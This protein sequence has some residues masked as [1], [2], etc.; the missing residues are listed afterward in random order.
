M[1]RYSPGLCQ[2]P[3]GKARQVTT[4]TVCKALLKRLSCPKIVGAGWL[5]VH[6]WDPKSPLYNV[7][8]PKH[9]HL[10]HSPFSEYKAA[11]W[12]KSGLRE[13]LVGPCTVWSVGAHQGQEASSPSSHC[14]VWTWP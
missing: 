13:E 3:E 6:P 4:R 2:V 14:E 1:P 5:W 8:I 9:Q 7:N 10:W 12:G 11:G